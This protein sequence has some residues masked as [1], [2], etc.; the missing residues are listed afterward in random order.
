MIFGAF[1]CGGMRERSKLGQTA[2]HRHH[3]E[4]LTLIFVYRPNG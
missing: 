4:A 2:E 1:P 3:Q